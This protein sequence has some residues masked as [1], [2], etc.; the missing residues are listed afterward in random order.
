MKLYFNK[1]NIR[2]IYMRVQG[3]I[4]FWQNLSNW[5]WMIF[6]DT[7]LVASLTI[8]LIQK[9]SQ[10]VHFYTLYEL[11][12][13]RAIFV[14]VSFFVMMIA[15]CDESY[16]RKLYVMSCF[17]LHIKKCETMQKNWQIFS[18]EYETVLKEFAFD[19]VSGS[20]S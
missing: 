17:H 1:I 15:T 3:T 18:G 16:L 5:I 20:S 2:L 9:I 12:R 19:I 6:V 14:C 7:R 10:L 11:K 4:F 8:C 13:F